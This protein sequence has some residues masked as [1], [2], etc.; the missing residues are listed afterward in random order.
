MYAY[1]YKYAFNVRQL[2]YKNI[3]FFWEIYFEPSF[4][5]LQEQLLQ[6]T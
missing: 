4:Y 2:Y 6:K 5:H 1:K 3:S